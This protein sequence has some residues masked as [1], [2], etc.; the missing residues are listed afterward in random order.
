[1]RHPFR[2]LN[3]FT[4]GGARLSGNPLCVFE[5][6]RT[7]SVEQMQALALQMNLSETTFLLPADDSQAL[8]RVRIFT[9][10]MELPFA[11]H[12][13]LGSAFVARDL[14]GAAGTVRL[15]MRAGTVAVSAQQ[16]TWSFVAGPPTS[17]PLDAARIDT[18]AAA[19]GLPGASLSGPPRWVSTGMEQLL[20][21]LANADAVDAASPNAGLSK[22]SNDLGRVGVYVFSP[23]SQAAM[24]VRFFFNK[25]A[26]AFAEDPATGSACANLGA[27]ALAVGTPLPIARVLSQGD[28]TGRPSRLLL[29]V[30]S[31]GAIGVSG[32][33]IELGRGYVDL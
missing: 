22:F 15:Q 2:I 7:M 10:A 30:D 13:T 33:V 23:L 5:D 31:Q 19:L 12:P 27:F 28:H 3:V 6:A 24:R 20:V 29:S 11:G 4:V 17:R 25:N 1:M 26:G 16:D 8:A 14:T 21:P 18:L 32:E 9:P